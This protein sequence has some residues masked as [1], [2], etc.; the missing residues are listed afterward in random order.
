M[1][2][3]GKNF[4]ERKPHRDFRLQ[5][6]KRALD[7]NHVAVRGPWEAR[8]LSHE[9]VCRDVAVE[10]GLLH[11]AFD[12]VVPGREIDIHGDLSREDHGEVCQETSFAGWE[13]HA[14]PGLVRARLHYFAQR[15]GRSEEL[16]IWQLR[17]V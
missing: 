10:I 12:R 9:R 14:H 4:A 8:H 15:D 3:A 13:H 2:D 1:T 5:A 17:I 6:W 16:G 7:E 11:R